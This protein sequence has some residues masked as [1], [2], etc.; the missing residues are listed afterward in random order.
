MR[1][2]RTAR[3]NVQRSLRRQRSQRSQRRIQ[4]RSVKRT[5]G[6][7]RNKINVKRSVKKS[8]R[9]SQRVRRNRRNRRSR[10]IRKQILNKYGGSAAE[11]GMLDR[12]LAA[13]AALRPLAR[14][15]LAMT[16]DA[17]DHYTAVMNKFVTK[18]YG[19]GE[20]KDDLIKQLSNLMVAIGSE[21]ID[22]GYIIR[23][24]KFVG[25]H[26]FLAL[27][28]D[29]NLGQDEDGKE[30][31]NFSIDPE[32]K[33]AKLVEHYQSDTMGRQIHDADSFDLTID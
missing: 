23:G 30:G 6:T 2:S 1:R 33:I 16:A 12:A 22:E 5:K 15:D 25:K 13:Q 7:R 19:E 24:G 10:Q 3:R 4:K 32:G 29:Y 11:K 14:P 28:A 27:L 20:T 18:W 21:E 17:D 9:R 26:I 31:A 8:N